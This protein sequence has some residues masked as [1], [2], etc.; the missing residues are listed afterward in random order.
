M[1][2]EKKRD[3]EAEWPLLARRL[4]FFLGRK[5][6][7]HAQQDDLIQDTALRLYKMWDS[8]DRTRPAWP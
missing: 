6:V 4:R 8:V 5:H 7:P 1:S 2:P 3:F